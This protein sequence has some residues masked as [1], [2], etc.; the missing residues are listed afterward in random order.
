MHI[1]LT[2]DDGPPGEASPFVKSLVTSL[3]A[4]GHE[5]SICLPHQQKSWIGKAHFIGHHLTPTYYHPDTETTHTEP[6]TDGGEEWTL[7]DGTPAAC[8]QIGLY[9]LFKHKGEIDLVISGPNFGRNSSATYALA[10]GTLGGA[11]EAALVGCKAISVSYA[12]KTRKHDWDVVQAASDL[13]ARIIDYLY[14]NWPSDDSVDIY[15]INVPLNE[16]VQH[17]RILTTNILQNTWSG[18]YRAIE[19]DVVDED[20]NAKEKATRDG[21]STPAQN[22]TNGVTEPNGHH[23]FKYKW[24]PSF[25][26]VEKASKAASAQGSDAWALNQG[27]VSVTPLKANFQHAPG[28]GEEIKL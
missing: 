21:T 2:N 1:L 28:I 24:A 22:L 19:T 13:S 20:P 12:Y 8:A 7:V 23:T 11:L 9:H 4:A 14:K 10:S 16:G 18:C 5:L 6:R 17:A 27:F 15:T 3:R 25:S 26:E